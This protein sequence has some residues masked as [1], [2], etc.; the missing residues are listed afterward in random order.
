[1]HRI[2]IQA[3]FCGPGGSYPFL[4]LTFDPHGIGCR[5]FVPRESGS[6]TN[7]DNLS[8]RETQYVI[9]SIHV[10]IMAE[11]RGNVLLVKYNGRLCMLLQT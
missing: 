11:R 1:M 5:E 3:V 4:Y 10:C 8:P 2:S 9:D 7:S 6:G